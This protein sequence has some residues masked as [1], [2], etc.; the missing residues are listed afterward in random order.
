MLVHEIFI[1]RKED[2]EFLVD[3]AIPT[4]PAKIIKIPVEVLEPK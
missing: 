1:C 4:E 3:D 2:I